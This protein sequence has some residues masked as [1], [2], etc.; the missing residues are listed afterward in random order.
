MLQPLPPVSRP[1]ERLHIDLLGPLPNSQGNHYVLAMIDAFSS[2]VELVPIADKRTDTVTNALIDTWVSHHSIPETIVSDMGKEFDSNVFKALTKKFGIEHHMSSSGHPRS[3]GKIERVNQVILLYIRKYIESNHQ[4]GELLPFLKLAMNTTKHAT[5][6]YSPY[7]MMYG[8]RPNLAT[9]LLCP[10]RTYSD[11]RIEQRMTLMARIAQEVWAWQKQAFAEQKRQFDKRA[12]EASFKVGDFVYMTRPHKGKLMQKFQP[13][14]EGP[15]IVQQKLK[16]DNYIV[17]EERGRRHFKVHSDR[18]KLASC[19]EQLVREKE[20]QVD[21]PTNQQ[22]KEEYYTGKL[23]GDFERS[24]RHLRQPQRVRHDDCLPPPQAEIDRANDRAN[25]AETPEL[26]DLDND[27][28]TDTEVQQAQVPH[29]NMTDAANTPLPVTPVPSPV[30]PEP[31]PSSL[32]RSVSC[33][34]QTK[35]KRKRANSGERD[36]SRRVRTRQETDK[37]GIRLPDAFKVPLPPRRDVPKVKR[38]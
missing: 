10:T 3:N 4:W 23:F 8:R 38:K 14:Y 7:F 30:P 16:M 5:R 9:M 37:A 6:D 13:L 12:K 36:D 27:E 18:L 32:Q 34:E 21:F 35:R 2:W 25:D 15:F 11:E 1:H 29:P 19:R 28:D 31:G 26:V 20:D 33:P 22:Q 24:L 17:H